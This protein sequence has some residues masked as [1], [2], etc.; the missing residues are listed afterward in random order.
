MKKRFLGNSGLEVSAL[1][2][3]CMGL[4]QSYGVPLPREQGVELID[5]GDHGVQKRVG[6]AVDV[7][8]RRHLNLEFSLWGGAPYQQRAGLQLPRCELLRVQGQLSDARVAYQEVLGTARV[9]QKVTAKPGVM[10]ARSCER[11]AGPQESRVRY[12]R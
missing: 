3:G 5:V 9:G 8:R 10:A 1:G 11:G 2:L 6:I 4:S 12:T 7:R